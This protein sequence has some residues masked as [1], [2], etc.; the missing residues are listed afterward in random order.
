MTLAVVR[1]RAGRCPEVESPTRHDVEDAVRQLGTELHDVYLVTSADPPVFLGVW[2]GPDRYGVIVTEHDRLT[3]IVNIHELSEDHE[4]IMCGGQLTGFL[5]C[6]L[7][8]LQTALIAA[9]HYLDTAEA[10]PALYWEW[11]PL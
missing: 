5:R 11:V 8:D 2:G 7:V 10:D 6:H 1:F 9:V 4:Q 3:N